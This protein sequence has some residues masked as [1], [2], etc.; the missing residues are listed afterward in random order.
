MAHYKALVGMNLPPDDARYEPGDVVDMDDKLGAQW[1]EEG[2]VEP[3]GAPK[4][5]GKPE[6]PVAK[7]A[8]ARST[9]DGD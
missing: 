9:K 8:S 7:S 2:L 3:V 5:K 6:A 4:P 1:T